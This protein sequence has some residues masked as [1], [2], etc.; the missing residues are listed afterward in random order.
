MREIPK[1]NYVLYAVLCI[2]TVLIV[3]YVM[4][5]YQASK[6]Y[7]K[8]NFIMMNFLSQIHEEELGSFLL[9]N[10][11]IVIYVSSS[12]DDQ[13]KG[14]EKKLKN[15]IVKE[16]IK[17]HFI[18]LDSSVVADVDKSFENYYSDMLKNK[19]VHLTCIPNLLIVENGEIVD[20]LY[21][22]EEEPDTKAVSDFLKKYGVIERD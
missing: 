1:K 3:F 11:E 5:W 12:A 21:K 22:F 13:Y 7:E 18:Y 9:E 10:P 17:T 15:L 14:F 20:I 4:A 16:E 19:N 8:G 2:V 6:N